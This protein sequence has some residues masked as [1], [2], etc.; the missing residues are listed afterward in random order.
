MNLIRIK[1][2]LSAIVFV[3]A[4]TCLLQAQIPAISQVPF[5]LGPVERY[6]QLLR[7]R[8][9]LVQRRD[10]LASRID[11]QR[12]RCSSVE[13]GS[14]QAAQCRPERD[15]L[16]AE[17]ASYIDAVNKFNSAL[18]SAIDAWRNQHS[19]LGPRIGGVAEMRGDV[20]MVTP[21]GNKIRLEPGQALFL[22]AHIQTGTGARLK[23]FLVDESVFALGPDSDMVLDEFVFDPNT[24]VRKFAANLI[25]GVFRFVTS[26]VG[27]QG[28]EDMHVRGPTGCLG[29]RGTDVE[30][31]VAA[32]NSGYIKLFSGEAELMN[33][34]TATTLVLHGGQM[35]TLNSDGTTGQPTPLTP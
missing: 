17:R 23:V 22:N 14:A 27:R 7:E 25:K 11:A 9:A 1:P 8:A 30:M 19:Q 21:D 24:S 2:P 35:L 5:S 20:F 3:L 16:N 34:K 4:L 13:V 29:I 31:F 26:K 33:H 32:D 10:A 18:Q 15:A 12:S 28:P 6:H